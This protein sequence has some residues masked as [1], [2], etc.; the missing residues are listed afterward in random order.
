MTT[1]GRKR[2]SVCSFTLRGRKG[3]SLVSRRLG[4]PWLIPV[5]SFGTVHLAP[6]NSHSSH[7]SPQSGTLGLWP[8]L[9]RSLSHFLLEHCPS[10][11]DASQLTQ[12]LPFLPEGLGNNIQTN[13]TSETG[14]KVFSQ[15]PQAH[16][17]SLCLQSA[18][19]AIPISNVPSRGA[20]ELFIAHNEFVM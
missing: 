18:K 6:K 8:S 9:W 4:L 5:V 14:L 12:S 13:V 1:L 3:Q 17:F 16:F 7:I 10:L 11:F 20:A 19:A 15:R 2:A